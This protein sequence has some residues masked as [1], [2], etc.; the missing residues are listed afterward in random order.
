MAVHDALHRTV[1]GRHEAR[2][3]H[4]AALVRM[5]EEIRRRHELAALDVTDA[6][7]D[8]APQTGRGTDDVTT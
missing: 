6:T 2:H 7:G 8:A 5:A 4:Q 3:D 1:T